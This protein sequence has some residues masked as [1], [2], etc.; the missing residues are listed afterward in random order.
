MRLTDPQ[1]RTVLDVIYQ[2]AGGAARVVLYGSRT[3]DTRRGGD[4]DLLIESQPPLGLWQRAKIKTLLEN[5]IGIP[6]DIIIKS[7]A[8]EPTPFQAIAL[9]TGHPLTSIP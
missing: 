9:M 2:E 1:I 3:D 7:P 4:I 6:V 8:A 5:A